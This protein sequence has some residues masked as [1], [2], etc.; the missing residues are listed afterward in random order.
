MKNQH[1]YF[2]TILFSLC[3]STSSGP[4]LASA[5]NAFLFTVWT[6]SLSIF[7]FRLL[8]TF[9][10]P[11]SYLPL[12]KK[13]RFSHLKPS[14]PPL[15]K[16][17]RLCQV[18]V[19]GNDATALAQWESPLWPGS[20]L[21]PW[22]ADRRWTECGQTYATCPM[23]SVLVPLAFS[24]LLP[25]HIASFSVTSPMPPFGAQWNNACVGHLTTASPLR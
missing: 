18:W 7:I 14:L 6:V 24:E 5:L 12:L 20:S 19:H 10:L 3:S 4:L 16:T 8:T 25:H 9:C 22:Y 23:F 21:P 2:D 13:P 17:Q 11:L 1:N 15:E